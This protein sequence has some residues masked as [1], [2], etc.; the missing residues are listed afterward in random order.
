MDGTMGRGRR[1]AMGCASGQRPAH[2][3][4]RITRPATEGPLKS[5]LRSGHAPSED[6]AAML[7][8]ACCRPKPAKSRGVQPVPNQPIKGKE[9]VLKK[10]NSLATQ[11]IILQ[12][13]DWKPSIQWSLGPPC[14]K[15][16]SMPKRWPRKKSRKPPANVRRKA[17]K[18][19]TYEVRLGVS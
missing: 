4:R 13:P 17:R 6:M 3:L 19:T 2:R 8:E 10:R 14:A 12:Q 16:Q 11:C 15:A 9:L 18:H 1:C 7:Q 5:W